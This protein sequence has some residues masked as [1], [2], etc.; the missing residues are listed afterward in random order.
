M[1]E[2]ASR[3]FIVTGALGYT[4]KCIARRLLAMGRRV[5]TLT[6]H[7]NR[8]NEFGKQL[9]MAP[10]DFRNRRALVENLRDAECLFNTYWVRFNHAGASF[11][12]AIANT[13]FLI[14]A[15]KEARVRK[16]VHISVTNASLGSHLPYY[17]GKAEVEAAIQQ[18]GMRFAILRPSLIFGLG[19]I[20]INNVAWFLRRFPVFAVPGS[21][22]YKLQPIH[23]EDVADLAVHVASEEANCTCDAVGPELLSF[24]ELVRLV[25][26]QVHSKARIVHL[27]PRAALVLL[28]L[29][30]I[31]VR[32]R[33]LTAGEIEGLMA[34]LLV[35]S[36]PPSGKTRFSEWVRENGDSLGIKYS[37]E[38]ARHFAKTQ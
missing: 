15:A 9:E 2:T 22:T 38:L 37:S 29:L 30:G 34:G 26:A 3:V 17:R 18:S 35:S 25:A 11:G 21:G 6:G 7:P 16:I 12:E 10:L 14:D 19:D 36:S 5:R 20:L 1:N 31:L 32:D 24:D 27:S 4:G 33:I 28:R 8:P 23:A 13:K